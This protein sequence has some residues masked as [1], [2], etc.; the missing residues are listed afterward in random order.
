[1]SYNAKYSCLEVM[2]ELGL[3]NEYH[4][5]GSKAK[6]KGK[7]KINTEQLQTLCLFALKSLRPF[8]CCDL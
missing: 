8:F 1:M 4:R 2:I 3:L 6:G 5:L 7:F